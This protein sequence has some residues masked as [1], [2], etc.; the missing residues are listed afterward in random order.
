GLGE[1]VVS[2]DFAVDHFEVDKKSQTISM[3]QIADKDRC[4]RPTDSGTR[5]A[6]VESKLRTQPCLD[7]ATI[8]QIAGLAARVEAYYS[9]PQDT[10]WAL[11]KG[12]LYLLQA[13]PV[14]TIAPRWTRDESAERFPQP[15]TPLSWDF[16][17]TGFRRS[18]AYSL[19]LMGL[20]VFRGDWF[21][22]LVQYIYGNQNA[23]EV[24]RRYRPLKARSLD[25][26]RAEIPQLRERYA[27][28]I[29]LPSR[30]MRDLDR[31]LLQIGE[32]RSFKFEGRST[33]EIWQHLRR[34]VQVGEEYFL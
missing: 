6:A 28:L 18:L 12:E 11:A 1:S 27:N 30:W 16:V 26:L 14:T 13:R 25:E 21:D 33:E 9:W 31:Y 22:R 10:E 2:G 3:R 17:Q 4:I 34:V 19:R 7:D 15:F 32:L 24:I 5:E 23:V 20:P 8:L 29:E